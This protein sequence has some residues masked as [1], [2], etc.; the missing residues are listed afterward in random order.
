[1][2]S[3]TVSAT[4][5]SVQGYG[6]KV[7]PHQLLGDVFLSAFSVDENSL[8]AHITMFSPSSLLLKNGTVLIH[9]DNDHIVPHQNTDVLIKGDIVAEIG[10]S[11][12]A[13]DGAKLIDCTGKI[14]SPGFIDT[15]H[16]LW[17]TQLKGRH[18]DEQLLE[19]MVISP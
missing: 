18:A 17:Q 2:L 4:G 6:I 16:H 5:G 10:S 11:L 15:H 1:V 3:S 9:D 12:S 8:Y 14:V 13:P 7:S 19:Y